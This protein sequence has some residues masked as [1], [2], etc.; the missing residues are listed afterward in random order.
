[1]NNFAIELTIR[2]AIIEL[3]L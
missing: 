2:V 1:L 3:L